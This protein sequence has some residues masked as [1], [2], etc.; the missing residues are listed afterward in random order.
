MFPLRCTVRDCCRPLIGVDAGLS[1]ESGHHFDRA[2]EGY[3]SLLQPQDRRS[4]NPGDT[5]EAVLARRRW[6]ERGH[7]AGLVDSLRG[8]LNRDSVPQTLDL[9][10]GEGSF[11]HKLFAEHPEAYCGIDLSKR[12][13]KLAARSWQPATWVWANAD[14]VLPVA[15]SSV[16]QVL[17]LF[18]RRPISEIQRVLAPGGHVIVAV[19]GEEDLIELREQTQQSGRRRS[20]WEMIA[21][22]FSVVGFERAEH[23]TWTHHVHLDREAIADALAMT[24][25]AVRRS[26]QQRLESVE[27]MDVTLAAD[28][29]LLRKC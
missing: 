9:G 22:E 7:V 3:F 21:E 23:Q 14:R 8:W 24:Y 5:D 4:K 26:Q 20:R 1:C 16:G 28:L 18:G 2:R 12:A 17:S 6:I 15:D 13:I 27:E 25:R 19:P 11:G 10:C 29:L